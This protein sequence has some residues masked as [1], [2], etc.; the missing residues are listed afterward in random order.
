[1][2][3]SLP[4]VRIVH[5]D[6][7]TSPPK[8]WA[9]V[10]VKTADGWSVEAPSQIV[11]VGRFVDLLTGDPAPTLAGFDFPIG[12]PNS[13]GEATGLPNF[14]VA[15]DQLG[16]GQ[17][18][19][20]C[21]PATV[22]EEISIYRPFYPQRASAGARRAH[23]LSGLGCTS[24]DQLLRRCEL[25]TETR[26]AACSLFWTLGG[27]QVGKAA[28]SGWQEVVAPARRRGA[29]IWPFDGP[30]GALVRSAR[31]T[32]VETYP[33]EAYGHVGIRFSAGQSKRRQKDRQ[34]VASQIEAWASLNQV[35]VSPELVFLLRDGF[36]P[37][38]SAEDPFDAVLGLLG[39]IEVVEG[40]R[41]AGETAA[42]ATWEGWI[43]GQS[44][45]ETS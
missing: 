16:C 4:F 13:Y 25:P 38:A 18:S 2:L 8:R 31:L 20:F 10:A 29:K 17:W 15:L 37:K 34:T 22:P 36:G 32:I 24:M 1:M 39:M 21:S 27:N 44:A 11:D 6:W 14:C 33:T 41:S 12:F 23:L 45:G 35:A 30:L 19:Q 40:R 28:I 3:Q 5:A 43:L 7:S 26:R 9:G 42:N